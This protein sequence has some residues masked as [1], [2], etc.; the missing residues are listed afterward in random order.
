M[1][2]SLLIFILLLTVA[3][4]LSA[5]EQSKDS[6]DRRPQ[7]VLMDILSTS[8]DAGKSR[9][10]T[11][12][13]R[14]ELFRTGLFGIVERGVVQR[15]M[16]DQRLKLT[17]ETMDGDILKISKALAVD[18]VLIC[19]IEKFSDAIVMNV[20][21]VD[22]KTALIDYTE[23][24]QIKSESQVYAAIKE[25]VVKIE[26]EYLGRRNAGSSV[27]LSGDESLRRQWGLAGAR[28]EILEYLASSKV[29]TEEFLSIRQYDISFTVD[30]YVKA[31]KNGIDLQVLKSFLQ[32]GIS[33]RLAEKAM[34]MGV[35]KLDNYR[36]SFQNEGLTFQDYLDAYANNILTALEYRA[37]RQGFK[38]DRFIISIGG[39]ADSLPI[40]AAETKFFLPSVGWEHYWTLYQRNMFKLSSEAGIY[41]LNF[42]LPVPYLQFNTY[43]GVY[44]FYFKLSLGA[45]A[46]FLVGGHAAIYGRLGFEVM[47]QYEVSVTGVFYGS[48]PA[49]SYTDLRTRS[50]EPGFVPIQ[51]P[52]FAFSLSYKI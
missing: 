12:L 8:Y 30:E 7:I 15:Y 52:Y 42:F 16:E 36:D 4:P 49:V 18:K 37:Y 2:K 46:E 28:G 40:T 33:Y 24:V 13:F 5:Q 20:R 11:D 3:V 47:E 38:T 21:I 1:K 34:S 27:N 41:L 31:R 44:P 14:S 29:S 9:L 6:K 19:S 45:H 17:H 51:Y 32:A 50:D 26:L 43:A 22:V 10:F 48:Q 23:S 39:A 25:S 35:V